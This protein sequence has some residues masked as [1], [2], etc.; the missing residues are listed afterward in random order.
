MLKF[1]D[2]LKVENAQPMNPQEFISR[3]MASVNA[4]MN[5]LGRNYYYM[6][7]ETLVMFK[8]NPSVIKFGGIHLEEIHANPTKTGAGQRFM[9]KI[10]KMAD[11]TNTWLELNAVPLK[12]SEKIPSRKLKNFYKS[13]GFIP[14]R[15]DDQDTM[16]RKPQISDQEPS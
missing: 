3:F 10:T 4:Q 8:M 7:G 9:Q 11:D 13:F 12:T 15:G 6:D 14:L 5:P 2:W 16:I 1:K